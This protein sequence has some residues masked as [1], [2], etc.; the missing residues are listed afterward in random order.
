MDK[1]IFKRKLISTQNGYFRL[2]IPPEIGMHLRG[3]VG[4]IWDGRGFTVRRWPQEDAAEY[5]GGSHALDGS[6]PDNTEARP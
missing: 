3:Q 6:D 4:I 2:A 5:C 1:L